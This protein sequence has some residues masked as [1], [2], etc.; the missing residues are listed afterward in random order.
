MYDLR[1]RPVNVDRPPL[2]D[3]TPITLRTNERARKL[4]TQNP[5]AVH[6]R[7]ARWEVIRRLGDLLELSL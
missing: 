6:F 1:S 3:L 2:S 7:L 5:Q 4:Q